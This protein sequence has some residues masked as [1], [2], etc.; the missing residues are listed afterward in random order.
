MTNE[1]LRDCPFCGGEALCHQIGKAQTNEKMWRVVCMKCI[2]GTKL[3]VDAKHAKNLWNTRAI[4]T[5]YQ[6]LLD[7]IIYV[8]SQSDDKWGLPAEA[9]GLLE[10]IKGK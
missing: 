7:F 1:T 9:R 8:S 5:K 2:T 6:E 4:D 10:M 3:G